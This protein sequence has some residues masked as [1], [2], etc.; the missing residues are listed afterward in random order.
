MPPTPKALTLVSSVLSSIDDIK[1]KLGDGEYLN[2]CNLLKALNDEIKKSSNVEAAAEVEEHEER[3]E[4]EEEEVDY[5]NGNLDNIIQNFWAEYDI[6]RGLEYQGREFWQLLEN[7]N[8]LL[9]EIHDAHEN[10]IDA[11]FFTCRCGC[12]VR[13][14]CVREH[15]D[16]EQHQHF[17]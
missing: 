12:V 5:I 16:T 17:L 2:L 7:Y 15:I 11:P 8:N 3:E 6:N 13:A 10:N 4:V 9:K 1:E 14:N